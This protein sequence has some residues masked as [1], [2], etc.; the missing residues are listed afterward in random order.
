MY[1]Y[2]LQF[3]ARKSAVLRSL[4]EFFGD[5]VYECIDYR[6]KDWDAEPYSEGSPVCTVGPGAMRYFVDGLR[7]PHGR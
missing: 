3:E 1:N 2:T 5:R 7:K 6:E 4:A